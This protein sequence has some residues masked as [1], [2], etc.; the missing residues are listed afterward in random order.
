MNY[1]KQL[2]IGSS[3]LKLFLTSNKTGSCYLKLFLS[4]A[5]N[6]GHK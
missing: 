2:I 6:N 4:V 3:Y 1:L 5:A